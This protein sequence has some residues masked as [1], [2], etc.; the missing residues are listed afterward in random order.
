MFPPSADEGKQARTDFVKQDEDVSKLLA[1][2]GERLTEFGG[3]GWELRKTA[4]REAPWF[5]TKEA[6][7]A[8]QAPSKWACQLLVFH[9]ILLMPLH[10]WET[11]KVENESRYGRSLFHASIITRILSTVPNV[12]KTLILVEE[13]QSHNIADT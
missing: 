5:K 8:R 1:S 6:K 4:L 3:P 10:N 13:S 9:P 2:F 7:C 11:R 12:T